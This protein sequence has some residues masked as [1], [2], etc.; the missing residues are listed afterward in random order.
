MTLSGTGTRG[1]TMTKMTTDYD[2]WAHAARLGVNIH[3]QR[4]HTANGLWLPDYRAI[5]LKPRM[6]RM[7]ERSVLTHELGHVCLGHVEDNERN[8]VRAD[9]WAVRKLIAPGS[10]ELVAKLTDDRGAW[11][12]ELEVSADL[13]TRALADYRTA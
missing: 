2:P 12:H 1:T 3:Y 4:L 6:R 13:L 9:R 5:I 7:I 10:L 11:C 8:E